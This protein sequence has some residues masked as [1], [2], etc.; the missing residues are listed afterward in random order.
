MMIR[1]GD[2]F[3]VLMHFGLGVLVWEVVSVNGDDIEMKTAGGSY[4]HVTPMELAI[5]WVREPK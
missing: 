4:A 3:R 5:D 1:V 2:R